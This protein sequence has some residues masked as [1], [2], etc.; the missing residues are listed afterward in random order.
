[1]IAILIGMLV[2]GYGYISGVVMGIAAGVVSW[3]I[4]SKVLGL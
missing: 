4:Y 3:G 1:M 2:A